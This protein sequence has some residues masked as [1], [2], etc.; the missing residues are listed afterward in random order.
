MD[1]L[2]QKVLSS[3]R[4]FKPLPNAPCW[5]LKR[6]LVRILKGYEYALYRVDDFLLQIQ[7]NSMNPKYKYHAPSSMKE[8]VHEQLQAQRAKMSKSLKSSKSSTAKTARGKSYKQLL[9]KEMAYDIAGGWDDSLF[10]N[11]FTSF[12]VVFIGDWTVFQDVHHPLTPRCPRH[13]KLL[14]KSR[15]PKVRASDKLKHI[16]YSAEALEYLEVLLKTQ[17]FRS[18]FLR[19]RQAADR[20]HT[21]RA[22]VQDVYD[23]ALRNW[24]RYGGSSYTGCFEFLCTSLGAMSRPK[25]VKYAI[26]TVFEFTEN[27]ECTRNNNMI[28]LMMRSAAQDPNTLD[29]MLSI[30]EWRIFNVLDHYGNNHSYALM[31]FY[32]LMKL[33]EQSTERVVVHCIDKYIYYAY[34]LNRFYLNDNNVIKKQMRHITNKF[35]QLT[36]S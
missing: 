18:W 21:K 26:D 10:Y 27:T 8:H 36:S 13:L 22:G 16:R 17:L 6:E 20:P 1:S 19:Q 33:M 15:A 25:L 11:A 30:I 14:K 3:T 24:H 32:L 23:H 9:Q 35:I 12:F 2:S 5:K 34:I 29:A 4:S 7:T 31:S 28:D